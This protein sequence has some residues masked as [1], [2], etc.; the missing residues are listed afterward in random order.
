MKSQQQESD[1]DTIAAILSGDADQFA[2]LVRRYERLAFAVALGILSDAEMSKDVVQDAFIIAYRDLKKLRD[3]ERFAAWL[4]GIVRRTAF[5]A[6][7]ERDRVRALVDELTVDGRNA[8]NDAGES[9]GHMRL[10][11]RLALRRLTG[12]QREAVS[13]HYINGMSYAAIARLTGTT[14][15][16]VQGRLQRARERLR[17]EIRA[18]E[19]DLTMSRPDKDLIVKIQT[20]IEAMAEG[21]REQGWAMAE[22]SNIGD[23]AVHPLCEALVD[24]RVTLREAAARTLCRI[25]DPRALRPIVRLLNSYDLYQFSKTGGL[26]AIPG[27]RDELLQL[28]RG[29]EELV[30]AQAFYSL[31]MATGDTGVRDEL[32]RLYWDQPRDRHHVL[33]AVYELDATAAQELINNHA[34]TGTDALL[35]RRIVLLCDGRGYVPPLDICVVA[36]H[37]PYPRDGGGLEAM[38]RIILRHGDA[39]RHALSRLLASGTR[40]AQV[41]GALGLATMGSSDARDVLIAEMR[42]PRQNRYRTK[43]M[44]RTLAQHFGN[45]ALQLLESPDRAFRRLHAIAWAVVHSGNVPDDTTIDALSRTGTPAVRAAALRLHVRRH[46]VESIDDLRACLQRGGPRKLTRAAF[47]EMARLREAAYSTVDAMFESRYW[48]ERKAAVALLRR[49]RRLEPEHR[50]RAALDRHIA[51][52]QAAALG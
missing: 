30:R 4:R 19:E 45:D 39:G 47:K 24:P 33:W 31:A 43:L 11:V 26:L 3:C 7:R 42:R 48:T 37:K 17:H 41:I 27:M 34:L 6:L 36:A 10:S 49:W 5:G 15:A 8:A 12:D 22:L 38:A 51:V 23:P 46:G 18:I 52:R 25:G 32:I 13:L 16:A 14:E 29:E 44:A 9:A 1:P 50:E 20:E 28:A 35:R 40:D 2:E 21:G